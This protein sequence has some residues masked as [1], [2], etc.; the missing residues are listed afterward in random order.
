MNIYFIGL[1]RMGL[2]MASRL[3][4]AG[5]A[6]AGWDTEPSARDR[7]KQ[8]GLAIATNPTEPG[9]NTEIVFLC[10][11]G[12]EECA[13]VIDGPQGLLKI[14]SANALI[15]D[16][17]TVGQADAQHWASAFAAAGRGN[18]IDAPITGGVL[19]AIE[20]TLTIFVGG[21]GANFQRALPILKTLG[22]RIAHIGPAGAGAAFKAINQAV[23]LTHC[24]ALAEA[25]AVA[26][27]VDINIPELL[28]LLPA[29]VAGMPLS[30]G[31]YQ[32]LGADDR[33]PGFAIRR[34]AK[35]IA[36]FCDLTGIGT[37]DYPIL[38]A[39]LERLQQ[40]IADGIGD[41]DIAALADPTVSRN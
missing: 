37:R 25:V 31:W 10:L 6:V 15:I 28:D 19:A 27:A 1:G 35:D 2:P 8:A 26:D 9:G 14:A 38:E 24:L 4:D 22:E 21:E 7:A 41:F 39:V 12:P 40:G 13:A 29:T 33:L 3:A 18:Y 17:S 30:S 32:R 34:A 5:H 20:G 16:T 23:Y 36:L 11:P